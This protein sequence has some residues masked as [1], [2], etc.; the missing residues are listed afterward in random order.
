[1]KIEDFKTDKVKVRKVVGLSKSGYSLDTEEVLIEE[2]CG[3]SITAP[4]GQ[5]YLV[6]TFEDGS[7]NIWAVHH[8]GKTGVHQ[9]IQG[10][11]IR[12]VETNGLTISPIL[13][14][15]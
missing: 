5:E 15:E 3:L 6:H 2:A 8:N 10:L 9:E 14:E 7:I 4:N 13:R 11:N 1:M 12:M